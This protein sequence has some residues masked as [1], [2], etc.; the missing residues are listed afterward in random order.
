M[1]SDTPD[2]LVELSQEIE[3]LENFLALYHLRY[4]GRLSAELTVAGSP[5]GHRLAPLLL[6]PFVENAFKH[7]ILDDPATPVRLHLALTPGT[8]EFTVENHCHA[9]SAPDHTSGIGLPNLRRRLELLYA[10]R[11]ALQA[12]P[13]RPAGS[14]AFRAQLELRTV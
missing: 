1:L 12:G 6:I 8:V 2:G 14:G 7:G 5:D 11:F 13:V 10:G 3:Y 9:G 4:P